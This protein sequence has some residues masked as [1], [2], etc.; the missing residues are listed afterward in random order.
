MK[1]FL[2]TCVALFFF[3]GHGAVADTSASASHR[4]AAVDLID[5]MGLE[6]QM[7]GGASAMVDAMSSQSPELRPYRDVILEWA[8][9]IMTWETFGP[10][11]TDIYVRAFSENEL[12]DLVAFYK[13]PTGKKAI[14]LMPELM[15]QGAQL[16]AN[17]AQKHVPRLQQM[18]EARRAEIA[19]EEGAD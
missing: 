5:L 11:M 19:A 12:K 4:Q 6:E 8:E 1:S 7:M 3:L 2:F 18:I 14:S 13:T 9:S 10:Q 16:G 15:Q 17:E